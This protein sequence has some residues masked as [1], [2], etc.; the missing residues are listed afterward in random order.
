MPLLT[1][2]A[3]STSAEIRKPSKVQKRCQRRI[4]YRLQS[5]TA[6]CIRRRFHLVFRRKLPSSMEIVGPRWLQDRRVQLH[7]KAFALM[8]WVKGE[9]VDAYFPMLPATGRGSMLTMKMFVLVGVR[10][11]VIPEIAAPSMS[12]LLRPPGLL[13]ILYSLQSL[14]NVSHCSE[15]WG[16]QRLRR[17][18][19]GSLVIE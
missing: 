9:E 7:Y 5:S 4:S 14:Q 12:M 10:E 8:P 13:A 15:T 3:R 16:G 1:L 17:S 19:H 11:W 6:Q 18:D 2:L